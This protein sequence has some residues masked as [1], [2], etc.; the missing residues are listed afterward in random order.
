MRYY[1]N[2]CKHDITKAEYLYSVD[3]FDRPLCR[4]H[5]A[6]ERKKRA[7]RIKDENV[8]CIIHEDNFTQ[9]ESK[10][11][12]T[13]EMEEKKEKSMARKAAGAMGR[14]I[15]RGV[16]GIVRVSKKTHQKRKW[17]GKILRR[18]KMAQLK[19]L[20]FERKISTKKDVLRED[21][22]GEQYWKELNCNK[23]D[24]VSRLK[25]RLSLNSIIIFAQR[26][27]IYIKDV[28]EEKKRKMAEWERK[29]VADK[30]RK[31]RGNFLL[32]LEKIIRE[33]KPFR[34]YNYELP[35]QDTLA[36]FLRSKYPKTKIEESKGSTRP[37]I[38]VRGVAIEIKGPTGAHDLDTI[39]NKCVRYLQYYP[40]GMICVLFDIEVSEQYYKDWIRG[41]NKKFPRVRII[42][43]ESYR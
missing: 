30:Y 7:Q 16:K 10:Q 9:Y 26:N 29:K 6:I 27:H 24:L 3:K 40:G 34:H 8:R 35:Y 21:K 13:A 11:E 25:N 32:E 12:I 5:Q 37:D 41:I 20:C 33:F 19:Q 38:V 4:K 17:K 1:C 31:D 43:I 36:A 23:A 22:N 28:L 15:V 2:I 14:G 42:R 18:M 39:A